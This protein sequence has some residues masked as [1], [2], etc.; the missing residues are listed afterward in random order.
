MGDFFAA[1]SK[2]ID[3]KGGCIYYVVVAYKNDVRRAKKK[4]CP[5]LSAPKKC[6]APPRSQQKNLAPPPGHGESTT[7]FVIYHAIK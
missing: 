7:N 4:V 2:N 3:N 6:F 1:V 5:P